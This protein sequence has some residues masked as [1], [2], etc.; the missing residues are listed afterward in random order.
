MNT[1]AKQELV[2]KAFKELDI[3]ELPNRI[4]YLP[5][6]VLNLLREKSVTKYQELLYLIDRI[7]CEFIGKEGITQEVIDAVPGFKK[8]RYG[9]AENRSLR[10]THSFE[11]LNKFAMGE[12]IIRFKALFIKYICI[13]RK[14]HII[15]YDDFPYYE[16]Y[17]MD[18]RLLAFC[19]KIYGAK[20]QY[21]AE[22]KKA[23]NELEGVHR[24][25]FCYY[26]SSNSSNEFVL[27]RDPRDT[28]NHL[29]HDLIRMFELC[30]GQFK[31]NELTIILPH[32]EPEL[33]E[34][35]DES[36]KEEEESQREES[37]K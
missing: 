32:L 21:V 29:C 22:L 26:I 24:V 6:H 25:F 16:P 18:E 27:I 8:G 13:L 33:Q 31:D 1:E 36:M 10:Q 37:L 11:T 14:V 20:S 17:M 34:M 35:Y 28:P 7:T 5:F 3:Y 12:K 19:K 4:P 30:F 9:S 2:E 23:K 15:C